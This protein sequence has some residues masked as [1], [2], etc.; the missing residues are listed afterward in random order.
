[1]TD[2]EY[3]PFKGRKR[4]ASQVTNVCCVICNGERGPLSEDECNRVI[5]KK[6]LTTLLQASKDRDDDVACR[7]QLQIDSGSV[8]FHNNCRVKYTHKN[9]GESVFK[10]SSEKIFIAETNTSF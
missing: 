10:V 4:K 9:R 2:P 5:S 3:T 7:I 8:K 1:M 6:G